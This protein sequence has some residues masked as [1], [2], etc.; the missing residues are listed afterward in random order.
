M[1]IHPDAEVLP[2]MGSD[3]FAEL[4]E[5]I[6]R[7]GLLCP[8][9]CL[10]SKIIDGRHRY[11]ACVQLGIEPVYDELYDLEGM[12]PGEYVW[13]LNGNRRHLTASQRAACYVELVGDTEAEAARERQ[14]RKPE[15]VSAILREQNTKASEVIAKQAGVS[16]R[17]VDDAKAVRIANPQLFEQVKSGE[18]SVSA[19]ARQVH[20]A[21]QRE[22]SPWSES[23]QKR[24]AAVEGGKTVVANKQQ[25]ARL[26][27]WADQQGLWVPVDRNTPWGNPFILDADGDRNTVCDNYETYLELKPSLLGRLSSLKGK[28]I[29][30]WCHPER[31]HADHLAALVNRM[32]K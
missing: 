11:K 29:G 12:T 28:V 1:Q 14:A 7:N 32:K 17:T 30:C 22:S 6:R 19:A 13:S 15:S 23:E 3:E 27:A 2:E 4:V 10:G 20:E 8:I 9:T 31:C 25:D 24:K 16:S 5:D 18:V 21:K 26:I